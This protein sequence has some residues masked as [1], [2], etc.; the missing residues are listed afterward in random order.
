MFVFSEFLIMQFYWDA[1]YSIGTKCNQTNTS[2]S[3][4]FHE[5]EI[6]KYD[7]KVNSNFSPECITGTHK[8]PQLSCVLKFD[9]YL[10]KPTNNCRKVL[11][12]IA[13]TLLWPNASPTCALGLSSIAFTSR[14]NLSFWQLQ[15]NVGNI[16]LCYKRYYLKWLK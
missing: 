4:I 14:S 3:T 13:R 11:Q 10:R 2:Q 1:L 7:F 9:I 6:N 12:E 16:K 8:F 15:E 5:D